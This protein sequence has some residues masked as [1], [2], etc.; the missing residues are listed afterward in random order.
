MTD[1]DDDRALV[2]DDGCPTKWE[3]GG[4]ASS[5]ARQANWSTTTP[6]G[7]GVGWVVSITVQETR[8][9]AGGGRSVLS[10]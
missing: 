6:P 2:D 1:T 3:P 9:G 5:T 4:C 10:G 8:F 7:T